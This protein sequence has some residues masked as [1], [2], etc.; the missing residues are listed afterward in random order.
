MRRITTYWWNCNEGWKFNKTTSNGWCNI[1]KFEY[2][3]KGIN[4]TNIWVYGG[5][6]W[7]LANYEYSQEGSRNNQ[8]E[9]DSV[10]EGVADDMYEAVH[11]RGNAHHISDD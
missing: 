5:S 2:V 4:K 3:F 7:I 8:V 11:D 10:N 9:V 1:R 6:D